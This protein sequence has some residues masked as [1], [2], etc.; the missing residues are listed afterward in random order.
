MGRHGRRA[1][2]RPRSRA[3]HNHQGEQL[4]EQWNFTD[5]GDVR[6]QGRYQT[7]W[8]ETTGGASRVRGRHVRIDASH[9]QDP[10]R[11]QRRRRGRAIPSAGQRNDRARAQRLLPRSVADAELVV[12]CAGR[13][14]DP[15]GLS[16]RLQARRA[17]GRRPRLSVRRERQPGP[18]PAVQL[19]LQRAATREARP[20][21]RIR[22]DMRSFSHQASRIPSRR[23]FR[24]MRSHSC[25]SIAT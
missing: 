13:R 20:S 16:R 10:R 3:H 1:H 21:P 9:G 5:L 4:L 6:I 2:R 15:A 8:G 7:L 11:E 24:R 19:R 17:G 12:V 14:L 22:E 25:R 23:P 18:Q